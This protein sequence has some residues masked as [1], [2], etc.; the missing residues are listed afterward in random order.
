MLV[1]HNPLLPA[2]GAAARLGEVVEARDDVAHGRALQVL[3]LILLDVIF[4][5]LQL[6]YESVALEFCCF[7]LRDRLV[8][9]RSPGV[10]RCAAGVVAHLGSFE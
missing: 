1:T 2:A 6:A 9:V 10:S 3:G 8:V 7:E 4:L 5:F